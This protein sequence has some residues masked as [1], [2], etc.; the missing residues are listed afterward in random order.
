MKI[1]VGLVLALLIGGFLLWTPD[2]S[3][4]WLD[5]RYAGPASRYLDVAGL[6]LHVR[7]TGP[8]SAPAVVMLHGLGASL[9]TW[10]AWAAGLSEHR[11]IRFDLPGFGL[12]VLTRPTTTRMR[13]A[14]Q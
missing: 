11:V 3:R 6:R 8:E 1:L 9:H 5:A 13:A 7:I 12:T 10:E 2:R 4:E 14:L